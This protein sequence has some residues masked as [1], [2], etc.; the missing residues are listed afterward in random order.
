MLAPSI[1]EGFTEQDPNLYG[2]GDFSRDI[3]GVAESIGKFFYNPIPSP[4][5]GVK[6]REPGIQDYFRAAPL[7]G[8]AIDEFSNMFGPTGQFLPQP[9]FTNATLRNSV[10][11]KS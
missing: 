4:G 3:L 9:G 10:R 6:L 11:I 2:L 7:S 1:A 5:A 8:A